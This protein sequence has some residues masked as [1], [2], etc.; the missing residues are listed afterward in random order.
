MQNTYRVAHT[1]AIPFNFFGQTKL[2]VYGGGL[3]SNAVI[4]AT[5]GFTPSAIVTA[6]QPKPASG[7][8]QF[9]W[10]E[11]GHA[12]RF[13]DWWGED[14][15]YDATQSR[16]MDWTGT[17]WAETANDSGAVQKMKVNAK[18]ILNVEIPVIYAH[19]PKPTDEA[20]QNEVRSL[21]KFAGR[22]HTNA[23]IMASLELAKAMP[24]LNMT[25]DQFDAN[26]MLLNC[27]NGTIDLTTGNLRP[28]ARE[29]YMTVTT[30]IE[31]A[32]PGTP[33]PLWTKFMD[34]IMGG[35]Q[36]MVDYLQKVIGYSISGDTRAQVF[37]LWVGSGSNGKST[38][39]SVMSQILGG[40]AVRAGN[41]TFMDKLRG[42][43][44]RLDI[45]KLANKRFV[46]AGET[47]E[48]R[49]WDEPL[50]KD[51]TGGETI[52]A[53]NL[54]KGLFEFQPK[55]KLILAGNHRPTIS[56]SGGHSIW[57]RVHLVPFDVQ[58]P[59]E[60]LDDQL[61]SK[62]L[63]EGPA[64]LRWAVD[65]CLKWQKEGLGMPKKVADATAE[66]R[67]SM[68]IMKSFLEEVFVQGADLRV[69]AQVAYNEYK[70][71]CSQSGIRYPKPVNQFGEM[72][73]SRGFVKE[74]KSNGN[75]WRGLGVASLMMRPAVAIT[76]VT[77]TATSMAMPIPTPTESAVAMVASEMAAHDDGSEPLVILNGDH[78]ASG[79]LDFG[80]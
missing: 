72:M 36:S 62:L 3:F 57:R 65:G 10:G 17:H 11:I 7:K 21:Q 77:N 16:W 45:A 64:I 79:D 68:D 23:G 31:V 74:V 48:N 76:P 14:C 53:R 50:I 70:Q 1:S 6:A 55:C 61:V 71:W 37:W 33:A 56:S 20:T 67:D 44:P 22:L 54:Y 8:S 73:K 32:A 12:E 43:G 35:D 26:P 29:D 13:A 75:F 30:P 5:I 25:G 15:R 2:P 28:H 40:Y 51:F 78:L 63:A 24:E 18:N 42:D 59:K 4:P 19:G 9:S 49:A 66:Y 69:G 58:F 39:L 46:T 41:E 47:G 27:K 80:L 34:Q 52:Q 60:S 38:T